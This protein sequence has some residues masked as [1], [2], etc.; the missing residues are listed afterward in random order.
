[1]TDTRR[2]SP[3][4]WIS[5]LPT[6]AVEMSAYLEGH[7]VVGRNRFDKE[8]R[9]LRHSDGQERWVNGTGELEF[10]E[11]GN[12]VR[13]IGTIRDIT[14]R[15]RT[16]DALRENEHLLGRSQE[17]ARLYSFAVDLASNRW[18]C[19]DM[20]KEIL[21][22]DDGYPMNLDG[23]KDLVHPDDWEGLLS[24]WEQFASRGSSRYEREF[25]IF[26]KA[27]GRER[28]LRSLGELEVDER[29]TPVRVVGMTMDITERKREEKEREALEERLRESH[30]LETVGRLAGGVAHEFNNM[31]SIILGYADL[32]RS[33]LPEGDPLRKFVDEIERAGGR[34]KDLTAQLLTFSRKQII[35]P[36]IVNLNDQLAGMIKTLGRLLGD[37]IRIDFLPGEGLWSVLFDPL[38]LDQVLV[39]LGINARD[40]MPGGRQADGRDGQR[41][42]G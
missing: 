5:S 16:E 26:R 24:S 34:V 31:L 14:E 28:W 10:D 17:V 36:K 39:N 18:S 23:W 4:G 3:A 21:G 38:Q 6:S 15:K 29:G 27:D 22:I 13:M 37:E 12:P 30:K 25:R 1:M 2:T 35:A 7:V 32:M 33:R 20:S 42:H 40:A 8:Y 41:M 19:S 9:I 11:R